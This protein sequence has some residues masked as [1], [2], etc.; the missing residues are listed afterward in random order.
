MLTRDLL[1]AR[2]Q[3]DAVIPSFVDPERPALRED[4]ATL[5]DAF[6]QAVDE[7]WERGRIEAE[8]ADLV[9][10]RRDHKVLRGLAKVLLDRSEFEV[11]APVPPAE[12]RQAV[13]RAARERGPLALERGLLGRPVAEDVLAEVGA[14][15]DL[16]AAR[17]AR[18]LYA[19]LKE[20]QRLVA[21][22]VTDPLDLLNRYNVALAQ[23]VLL[24]ATQVHVRLHDP[25][26]PRLRQLFRYVKFY[27]LIWQATRDPDGVTITLDG[28]TSLFQMSTR[29]GLQ[30]AMFLP[31]LLL[32][33]CPWT[34]RATVLWTRGGHRKRLELSSSDGL[35]S[36]YRDVGAYETRTQRW[37]VERFEALESTWTLDDSTMPLDLGGHTLV[38]PDFR[39]TREGR[40]AYLEIVGFWRKDWLERRIRWLSEYAPGN[41]VLAVSRKL[42]A[43]RENLELPG[44]IVEFAEVVPARKVLEAVE[45]IA[46]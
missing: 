23:A 9:G 15:Y 43:S 7:G 17:T 12:L 13:F 27:E 8:I 14:R 33:E 46:T 32:Q 30:L 18:V 5:V 45:R 6:A 38:L 40:T 16:D 20:A 19:D 3:K 4:A 37:F 31:A 35:V 34:L 26:V 1:R 28:P 39:F 36:H 29:Y 10:D 11:D 24:R 22:P 21:C 2:V 41:L 25:S 42:R 44:E